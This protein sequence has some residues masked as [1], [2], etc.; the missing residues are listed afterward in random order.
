MAL[1]AIL[2][3]MLKKKEWTDDCMSCTARSAAGYGANDFNGL[4]GD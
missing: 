2:N 1:R 3:R 4:S